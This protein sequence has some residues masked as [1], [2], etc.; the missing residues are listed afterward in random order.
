MKEL[1]VDYRQRT[2]RDEVSCTGIGLHTGKKVKVTIK[3]APSDTGIKFIRKDL[4]GQPVIDAHSRNVTDTMLSTTIG[5]N[6][7]RIATIEHLMAAFFGLGIDN[8]R[9][10]LDGPEVPSMDGS[11]APFVFLL[12]SVGIKEQKDLKRFMIIKKTF[13]LQDGNRSICIHPSKELR[14]T[15]T[16]DFDHPMLRN[17]RYELRFSGKDF[18]NEISR[19]RTFGFLK[20]VRVLR[21]NGLAKG[22]SLDNAIII[23]DFRIINEDGLRYADEFVRHKILDF[24]GDLAILGFPIIGHFEVQKSG[25]YLNQLMLKR[26]MDKEKCWE[27]V[28]FKNPDECKQ[29]SVKIPVF[30]S[31]EPI[32]A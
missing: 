9:V 19:A 17:Q 10:E 8:A 6:G 26:L 24:I 1:S 3:P 7:H 13:K 2:L 12:K 30:G 20:D 18:I 16:I 25:H 31:I 29:T 23:D 5:N 27:M 4:T 15:Y 32:P 14:I 28:T 21:E 22:G 11:S